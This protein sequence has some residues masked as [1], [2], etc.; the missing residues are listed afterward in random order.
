MRG[1]LLAVVLSLCAI[2]SAD[3][4]RPPASPPQ[5][6]TKEALTADG[7]WLLSR[8]TGRRIYNAQGRLNAY[9]SDV[10]L[11]EKGT[12]HSYIIGH[13]GFLG[14]GESEYVLPAGQMGWEKGAPRI[15]LTDEQLR[16]LPRL[17]DK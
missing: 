12:V 8:I 2:L 11:E 6:T 1:L 9:V 4:Q 10:L 13:G 16:A 14:I 7:K 3:A 17:M 5:K 15:T